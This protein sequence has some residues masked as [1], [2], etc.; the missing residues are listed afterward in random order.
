MS[1]VQSHLLGL[2][3]VAVENSPHALDGRVLQLVGPALVI[4]NAPARERELT[5]QT[6]NAALGGKGDIHAWEY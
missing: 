3:H 4:I 2:A 6:A 5:N 1:T